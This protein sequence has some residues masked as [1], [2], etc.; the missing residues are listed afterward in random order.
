MNSTE[1]DSKTIPK[2]VITLDQ[3]L[4]A[5]QYVEAYIKHMGGDPAVVLTTEGCE[6]RFPEDVRRAFDT[7]K[8]F[9]DEQEEAGRTL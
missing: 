8:A 4:E 9:W 5:E 6:K 3:A 7:S 2:R 1:E